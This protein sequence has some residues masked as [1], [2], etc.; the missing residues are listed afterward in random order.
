MILLSIGYSRN[1]RDIY[2]RF[3]ELCAFFK[4]KD[5]SIAIAESD[6]SNMHYIKCI[7]KDTEKDIKAFDS[8]RDMFYSYSANVI[9]DY[10]CKEYVSELLDKL[11]KENYSY[12]GE[13]EI[14]ELKER[15]ISVIAGTGIFS[16]EGLFYSIN[17]KNNM[18]KKLVEYF[19]ESNEMILDGFITFRLRDINHEL[20]MILE[21]IVE[22]YIIEKEYSEFIKLLKY[23]VDIQES[24]YETVNIIINESGD[25][26]IEDEKFTNITEEFFEDFN[27]DN[28]K[29]EINKNDVLVSALITCAP[30]KIVVHGLSN[31]KDKEV[32]D[33]IKNIF[34]ERITF[35]TGCER[36]NSI[37]TLTRG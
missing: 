35:C 14:D 1:N 9:Y 21:K 26:I 24:R 32:M 19:Q 7:L 15:C 13:Q 16:T 22:D 20:N 10:I 4:E 28:I 29:G 6:I 2:D 23:F 8:S 25:F 3:K 37:N 36:C 30:K 12:V 27:I 33:T 31:L 5:I 34:M 17:C 11:L 18:L